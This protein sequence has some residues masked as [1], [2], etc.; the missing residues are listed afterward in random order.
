LRGARWPRP[1][2]CGAGAKDVQWGR[3]LL[4]DAL[5]TIVRVA[6]AGGGRVI[7]DVDNEGL[8]DFYLRNGFK[9]TGVT[10]DLTL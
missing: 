8:R 7:V 2:Q 1:G 5:E 4:R 9:S 10:R 6:D 3:Q